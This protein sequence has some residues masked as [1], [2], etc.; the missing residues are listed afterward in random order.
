MNK[1]N[2]FIKENS[3]LARIAAWKL[4]A[5]KVAMVIGKT[6]HLHNTSSDEF[7]QNKR[8]KKHE[9]KHI[10]QFRRHGFVQFLCLYLIESL[11][12]GYFNNRFEVEARKAETED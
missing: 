12:R 2:F 10:E 1:E 6:I 5:P 9:L 8:W 11:R 4:H 3:K 7:L